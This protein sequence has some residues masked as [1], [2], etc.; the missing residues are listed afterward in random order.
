MDVNELEK[1]AITKEQIIKIHTLKSLMKMPDEY[2]RNLI[3]INFYPAKSSKELNFVNA[4]VFVNCLKKMAIEQGV[5]VE[6]QGKFTYEELGNR[7]GMAKPSQLRMIEAI[8]KDLNPN[9]SEKD[10]K[11]KLRGWLYKYF[12]VSDMK[13]LDEI[14]VHKVIHALK[15]MQ[16]RKSSKLSQ[17]DSEPFYHDRSNHV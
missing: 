9:K 2:Y 10:R 5:W 16:S 12:D 6:K 11:R 3:H 8:W 7:E 4:E 13:F 17:N 14:R 1:R 15:Q